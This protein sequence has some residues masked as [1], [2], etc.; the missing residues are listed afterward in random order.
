[1]VDVKNHFWCPSDCFGKIFLFL[2]TTWNSD[3]CNFGYLWHIFHE[4][5]YILVSTSLFPLHLL[6]LI[7]LSY[8]L[9]CF[10]SFPF[11]RQER[12]NF[13]CITFFVVGKKQSSITWLI[14]SG[15]V[16]K[17][18]EEDLSSQTCICMFGQYWYKSK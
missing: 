8:L 15:R 2:N 12:I 6:V 7:N 4:I 1:M 5:S 10:L 9:V 17:Y 18:I 16:F 13:L 11:E 14:G 3:F